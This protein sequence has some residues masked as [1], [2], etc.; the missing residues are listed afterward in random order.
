MIGLIVFFGIF[1]GGFA[2]VWWGVPWLSERWMKRRG[3]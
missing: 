1:G 2:L 3:S